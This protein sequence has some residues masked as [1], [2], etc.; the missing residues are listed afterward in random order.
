MCVGPRPAPSSL[1]C[2]PRGRG[3]NAGSGSRARGGRAGGTS[4]EPPRSDSSGPA[5]PRSRSQPAGVE[6]R[7]IAVTIAFRPAAGGRSRNFPPSPAAAGLPPGPLRPGPPGATKNA[8]PENEKSVAN[9]AQ[10]FAGSKRT[11]Y[12][13]L[14]ATLSEN[15][16]R[17]FPARILPYSED[18]DYDSLYG[19][20]GC[21]MYCI[22]I[23]RFRVRLGRPN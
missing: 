17:L 8:K 12:R 23:R 1:H 22:G 19:P 10:T 9:L 18:E 6:K 3:R 21:S 14:S 4:Q 13:K 5:E 7:A 15:S 2:R 11:S 20:F 16:Q